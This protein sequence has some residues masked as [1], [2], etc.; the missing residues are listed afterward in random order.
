VE[1]AL[2]ALAHPTRRAILELVWDAERPASDIADAVGLSRPAASQHLRVLLDAD[3][4]TVRPESTRRLYRVRVDRVEELRA[5]L[6][7]FWAE[8][9][10]A[11]RRSAEG[12]S[13]G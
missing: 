7:G 1:A 5:F 11:L 13:A 12:R 9:L 4:V 3:L 6:E 8:R 10:D 2:R